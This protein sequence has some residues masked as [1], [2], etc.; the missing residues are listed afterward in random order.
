MSTYAIA[1]GPKPRPGEKP[2]QST[3]LVEAQLKD[4][5]VVALMCEVNPAIINHL[6]SEM[7]TTGF[8]SI[9]NRSEAI[10]VKASK[11]VA[12]RVLKITSNG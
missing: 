6:L 3:S 11:V 1:S 5:T 12:V 8:L 9:Y 10:S 2:V 4:G 7:K